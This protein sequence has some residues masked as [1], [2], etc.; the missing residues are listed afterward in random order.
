MNKLLL[1]LF[2]FLVI[3]EHTYSQV[4][5]A[6][7]S[8]LPCRLIG[9]A[10]FPAKHTGTYKIQ[11]ASGDISS[12]SKFQTRI[13]KTV[14]CKTERSVVEVPSFGSAYTWRTVSGNAGKFVYGEL[15]HFSTSFSD[16]VA[17]DKTRLKVTAASDKYRDAYVF[18]DEP[19]VLYDMSGQPVW[20]MPDQFGKGRGAIRDLKLTKQGT[21]TFL[22]GSSAYEINYN[23]DVLWKAPDNGIVSGNGRELYHH[24]FTRLSNGHYM[25]LGN[26]STEMQSYNADGSA[27][28]DANGKA[29]SMPMFF[30]TVIEYDVNGNVVWSWKSSKYAKECDL[31]NYFNAD[32]VGG[33]DLHENA[34]SFDEKEKVVYVSFK[35]I[36]RIVKIKYPEGTVLNTFGETYKKGM[37]SANKRLF[38]GQHA[39]KFSSIG[40]LFLFNNNG[41][42]PKAGP[43]VKQFREMN[44]ESHSLRELW[45][46]DCP[47]DSN[48]QKEFVTGGNVVELPDNSLLVC[49][50]GESSRTFI[51]SMDK[52]VLW[53]AVPEQ[54]DMVA[55]AW[56]AMAGYRAS[57]I[58]DRRQLEKL[59]WTAPSHPAPSQNNIVK[60]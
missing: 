1:I 24:E 25:V 27:R 47:V 8:S 33:K 50:G 19:A 38:C 10:P 37:L 5:P 42:S 31:V 9:F 54:Y 29:I 7:G 6:E 30:G 36:N 53:S 15:H 34:F 2:L 43:K 22:A 20:F 55:N 60:N 14:T 45:E 56:S 13:I 4:L 16:R 18:T 21:I 39:C 17:T 40:C 52:K 11:I 41:C 48:S 12:G 59:I 51:V 28:T 35:N 23:G 44:D 32:P 46:Y 58:T 3:C 49:M 26:E 57:M